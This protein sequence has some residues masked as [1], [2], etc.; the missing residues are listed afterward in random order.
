MNECIDLKIYAG[1]AKNRDVVMQSSS[2]G[3][4]SVLSDY[5]LENGD[6]VVTSVYD[7]Q[8]HSIEY[9]II[10]NKTDRD[11]ARGSKYMQSYPR[12]IFKESYKWLMDHPGKKILFVG[13]GCQVEGFRKYSEQMK[14]RDRIYC[15]DIICHGV[16]SPKLWKEYAALLEKRIGRITY[17]TFKDK[18][19]GWNNPYAFV[20][21]GE[22][23]ISISEFVKIFYDRCGMRPSCHKCLFA[24]KERKSDMTIGDFWHIEKTIPDF[25]DSRGT[26]VFL[27]H[28]F[29]GNDLF[30]KVKNNLQ[31]RRSNEH[32][33]WQENLEKPT[34][35]SEKRNIFWSDYQKKGIEYIV[36]KYG[37]VP[38]NIRIRRCIKKLRNIKKSIDR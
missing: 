1:R 13:T 9:K 6:A 8:S 23:E 5:F 16:A 15:V 17:I 21:A 4:F 11:T 20:K 24:C 14:I 36:K 3:A 32:E 35:I 29:K 19:N 12:N 10:E 25:Y 33:C 28:T 30:D 22:R 2:G 38:F 7:Y 26:S 18:R 34:S 27:I 37:R 31:Y